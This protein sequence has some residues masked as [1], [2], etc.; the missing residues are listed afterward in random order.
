LTYFPPIDLHSYFGQIN[1]IANDAC[2]DAR[3]GRHGKA[4]PELRFFAFGIKGTLHFL[5]DG[6]IEHAKAPKIGQCSSKSPIQTFRSLLC[7]DILYCVFGAKVLLPFELGLR[8]ESLLDDVQWQPEN[9]GKEL[10]GEP[11]KHMVD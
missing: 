2:S 8:L 6:E 1:G 7:L 11:R 9:A 4:L 5:I 10:G 3:T